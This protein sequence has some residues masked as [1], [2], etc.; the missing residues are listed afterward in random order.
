MNE[1][2]ILEFK[3]K[4]AT[5]LN[6]KFPTFEEEWDKIVK[7]L[8]NDF[9]GLIKD[10]LL[11]FR[12]ISQFRFSIVID[13]N[14]IFGQIKNVVEKNINIE[15]SFIY[16]L[17]NS[18]YID[19]YAPCKL[20]DELYDKIN[21]VL[22]VKKGSAKKYANLLIKRI[23]I[24]DAQ[25]VCEWKKANNLIG[26]ID[27]DDVPYLALA[28]HI[29]SHAIISYDKVFKE[30][31]LSK[32][33]NIQ[34]TDRIITSYNSGVISF[35][36]IGTGMSIIELIWKTIVS[37]FKNIGEILLE[38][39][40]GV[41]M[42]VVGAFDLLKKI[43]PFIYVLI[44]AIGIGAT[45][46]SED[47]RKAGKDVLIKTGDIAKEV[48]M[49]IDSFLKWLIEIVKEFWE[50]FKPIG[51]TGFEITSYF[52]LEYTLMNLQVAKLE[53]ERAKLPLSTKNK[54]N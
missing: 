19:V 31:S 7:T 2:G 27:K 36:F 42:L 12:E 47:F 3:N 14:F 34:D 49:K 18:S 52:I 50:I 26:H 33:W 15:N 30:Q 4:I 38:I 17:V 32:S 51:I 39:I 54:H 1:N 6:N 23:R 35:C 40:T 44:L 37:I 45:I 13:N 53:N 22:K 16:K 28:F 10:E 20:K 9:V 46:Y 21:T 11:L 25:W 48:I 24:K 29:E 41:G 5:N 8:G 43:P